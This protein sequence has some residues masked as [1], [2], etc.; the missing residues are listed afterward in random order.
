VA[1]RKELLDNYVEPGM[2]V[3]GYLLSLENVRAV[4]VNPVDPDAPPTEEEVYDP[5]Y[6]I[7]QDPDGGFPYIRYNVSSYTV[8]NEYWR[9]FEQ[10]SGAI[11]DRNMA[12]AGVVQNEIQRHL[13]DGGDAATRLN[14]WLSWDENP[15]T[16]GKPPYLF[17]DVTWLAGGDMEPTSEVGGAHAR[18]ITLAYSYTEVDWDGK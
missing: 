16:Q 11:Y 8:P 3:L 9:R 13:S 2:C 18:L 1:T 17:Y 15:I 7:Q 6:P 12:V 10:L 14:S 5:I 4:L